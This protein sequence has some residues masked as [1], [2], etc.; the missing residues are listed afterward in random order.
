MSIAVDRLDP[1]RQAFAAEAARQLSG[2]TALTVEVDAE[3]ALGDLDLPFAEE[4]LAWRRSAPPT[5]SRCSRC[6]ASPPAP[7]AWWGRGTCS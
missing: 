3:V 4:L 6:V 5:A 1:F 2:R 7:P